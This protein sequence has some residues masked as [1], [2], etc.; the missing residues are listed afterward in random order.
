MRHQRTLTS[1]TGVS[2]PVF[3]TNMGF[4]KTEEVSSRGAQ[5]SG[6]HSRVCRPN[7]AWSL[8]GCRYPRATLEPQS[9]CLLF[10]FRLFA[11]GSR[12]FEHFR[13]KKPRASQA[14]SENAGTRRYHDI[15]GLTKVKA[16]T[17]MI[18]EPEVSGACDNSGTEAPG[19]FMS[20]RQ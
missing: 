2:P 19:L 3:A 18:L 11:R 20:S 9:F 17:S 13:V 12:R 7:S 4:S 16:S 14:S 8:P 1:R 10:A 5:R 15:W 6:T